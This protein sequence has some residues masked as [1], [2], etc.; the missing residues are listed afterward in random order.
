MQTIGRRHLKLIEE[1]V[2]LTLIANVLYT[3][4]VEALETFCH[5]LIQNFTRHVLFFKFLD[6]KILS[7]GGLRRQRS[8]RRYDVEIFRNSGISAAYLLGL[9]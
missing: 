9:S 2:A 8:I 5:I 3:L 1:I 7:V 6:M 4:L